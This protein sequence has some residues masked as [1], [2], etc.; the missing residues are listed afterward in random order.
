MRSSISSEWKSDLGGL[1]R[2][3]GAR[4]GAN[5]WD[6]FPARSL[7][8]EDR[9]PCNRQE[10]GA[11]WREYGIVCRTAIQESAKVRSQVAPEPLD[12]LKDNCVAR[13]RNPWDATT[14]LRRSKWLTDRLVRS[15]KQ[16][17]IHVVGGGECVLGERRCCGPLTR[18]RVV[19]FRVE[20]A[21]DRVRLDGNGTA[22]RQVNHSQFAVFV[23]EAAHRRGNT[24]AGPRAEGWQTVGG[25]GRRAETYFIGGAILAQS[26]VA[27][28]T[29]LR[30]CH[31]ASG[32]RL[33][34]IGGRGPD[35]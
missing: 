3:R 5:D 32:T 11:L 33:G 35:L 34:Y 31:D 1:R 19:P 9:S 22:R 4:P 20:I 10:P 18:S 24:Q 17:P 21:G 13:C 29:V 6:V 23:A 27:L 28:P 12:P 16:Y 30:Y 2:S 8:G 25:C 7:E 15:E 26:E 14:S